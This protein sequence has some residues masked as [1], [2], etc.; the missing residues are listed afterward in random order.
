MSEIKDLIAKIPDSGYKIVPKR[1][2]KTK[3]KIVTARDYRNM[4]WQPR[5]RSPDLEPGQL[6]PR[7]T[8]WDHVGITARMA[9]ATMLQTR[10]ELIASV[11]DVGQDAINDLLFRLAEAKESLLGVVAMT[12]SAFIRLLAAAHHKRSG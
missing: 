3:R 9:Y 11:Q 7:R 4:D 8:D 1:R 5:P 10:P 2:K 12:D 6:L